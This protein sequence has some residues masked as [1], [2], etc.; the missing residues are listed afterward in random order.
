MILPNCDFA[1]HS[2]PYEQVLLVKGL[3]ERESR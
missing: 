1:N 3:K 2:I